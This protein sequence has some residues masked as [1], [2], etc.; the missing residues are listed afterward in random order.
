MPENRI[1]RG[2]CIKPGIEL[3]LDLDPLRRAFLN[4]LNG[5]QRVFKLKRR[6]YASED[7]IRTFRRSK[8]LRFQVG[9]GGP[10]EIDRFRCRAWVGV[11]DENVKTRPRKYEGP[12]RTDNARSN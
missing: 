5:L 8:A 4:V 7:C 3:P 1:G 2:Q 9:Q 11:V 10:N 6:L 12:R